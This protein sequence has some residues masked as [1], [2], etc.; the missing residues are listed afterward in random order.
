MPK[1]S[2]LHE[3]KI[4]NTT[5]LSKKKFA[6]VDPALQM[7]ATKRPAQNSEKLTVLTVNSVNTMAVVENSTDSNVVL[8]VRFRNLIVGIKV[9][10]Q[11]IFTCRSWNIS[12]IYPLAINVPSVDVITVG[13][14]SLFPS[15][16]AVPLTLDS[17]VA[18][19]V[20]QAKTCLVT[21]SNFVST[22]VSNKTSQTCQLAANYN[23]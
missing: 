20:F 6:L 22:F 17:A 4:F 23:I 15:V 11:V 2:H 13:G 21:F 14:N 19:C 10:S 7:D 9:Y 3:Q 8:V 16:G 18:I 5:T 1:I 12:H